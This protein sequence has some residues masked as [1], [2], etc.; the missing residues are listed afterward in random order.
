VLSQDCIDSEEF[1]RPEHFILLNYT[2]RV[3]GE[4]DVTLNDEA[5]AYRW[6]SEPDALQLDLNR[7]TRILLDTVMANATIPADA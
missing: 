3:A 5:Q 7:P 1:Y 4:A 6:V 2:C